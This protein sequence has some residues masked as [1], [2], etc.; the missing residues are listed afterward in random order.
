LL[1][2]ILKPFDMSF[3]LDAEIYHCI[4]SVIQSIKTNNGDIN[5]DILLR[6]GVEDLFLGFMNPTSI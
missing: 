6:I 3:L 1:Y 5:W 2:I 4:I